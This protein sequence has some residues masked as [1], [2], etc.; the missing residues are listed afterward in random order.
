VSYILDALKRSEQERRRAE[1]AT[2]ENIVAQPPP[3]RRRWP[4]A[5]AAIVVAINLAVLAWQFWPRQPQP[6][7]D[8]PPPAAPTPPTPQPALAQLAGSERQ[9]PVPIMSAA[10]APS[11]RPGTPPA[12]E[13]ANPPPSEPAVPAP[14]ANAPAP[15]TDDPPALAELPESF[16]RQLP[17]LNVNVHVYAEQPS[18]RFVL[19]DMRRFAEGAQLPNGM[20]LRRIT[21]NGLVLEYQGREFLMVVR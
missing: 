18:A 3:A 8:A 20:Y 11:G 13:R 2:V 6:A 1:A 4:T 12:A 21:P 16:R 7:P 5:L 14:A 19:I 10:P 9:T 17:A 15:T